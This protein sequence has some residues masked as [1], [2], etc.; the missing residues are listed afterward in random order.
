LTSPFDV[1]VLPRLTFTIL[2]FF[3]FDSREPSPRFKGKTASP[4]CIE[5]AGGFCT[6]LF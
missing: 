5:W 2:T 4:F 1:R 3:S 6:R